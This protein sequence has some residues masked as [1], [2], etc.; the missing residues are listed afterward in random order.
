MNRANRYGMT[1]CQ[2]VFKKN[3]FLGIKQRVKPRGN[4]DLRAAN[5]A[6][7]LAVIVYEQS[8]VNRC[9][10]CLYFHATRAGTHIF[11]G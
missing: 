10:S 2:I 4:A 5:H 11:R 1:P 6:V 9:P 8:A 7:K 3:Q